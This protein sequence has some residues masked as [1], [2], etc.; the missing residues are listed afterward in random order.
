M[1]ASVRWYCWNNCCCSFGIILG[2]CDFIP[3]C[4]LGVKVHLVLVIPPKTTGLH[5]LLEFPENT[6]LMICVT[7]YLAA[8]ST[9]FVDGY[10]RLLSCMVVILRQ[11]GVLSHELVV[12]T[13]ILVLC[14]DSATIYL[15]L[16]ASRFR[17][18]SLC[19]SPN[20]RL[21][22]KAVPTIPL[23]VQLKIY[24]GDCCMNSGLKHSLVAAEL[25]G[26]VAV[27]LLHW[28]VVCWH[29]AG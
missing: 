27:T 25:W 18:H 22:L 6:S 3:S 5:L 24:R 13:I 19:T 14:E 11:F 12:Q 2:Q 9:T 17:D 20:F 15:N 10:P 23:T 8:W 1:S 16:K 4:I 26:S 21:Q 28:F 7:A 29:F